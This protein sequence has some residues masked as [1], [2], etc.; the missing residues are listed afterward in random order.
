[1]EEEAAEAERIRLMEEEA[2]RIREEE[3]AHRLAEEEAAAEAE[4]LRL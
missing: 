1:M 4:R 3:E 2:Q